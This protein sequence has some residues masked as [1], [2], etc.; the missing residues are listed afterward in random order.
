MLAII[1]DIFERFD[2]YSPTSMEILY[3]HSTIIQTE[4]TCK[5][6]FKNL[7]TRYALQENP[8]SL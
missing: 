2:P 5:K 1:D 6:I 4:I 8:N 7:F 3:K